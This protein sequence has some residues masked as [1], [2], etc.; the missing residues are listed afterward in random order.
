MM[1]A[2]DVRFAR[3]VER[4]HALGARA[5]LEL[6]G[7]IASRYALQDDIAAR[8]ARYARL[9]PEAVRAVGAD[10]LPPCGPFA[11]VEGCRA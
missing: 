1:S 3:D 6:L 9:S 2:N 10:R 11:V 8:V 7:E 4:V 5:V